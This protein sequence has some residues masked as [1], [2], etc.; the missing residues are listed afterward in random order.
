LLN[1]LFF[2]RLPLVKLIFLIDSSRKIG[3]GSYAQYVFAHNLA[4]LG[5][6]VTIF[7]GDKNFYS[8]NLDHKNLQVYYRSTIPKAAKGIGLGKLNRWWSWFYEW[9]VIRPYIKQFQP[10]WIIGYLHQSAIDA[11]SLGQRFNTKVANFVYETPEW[12]EEQLGIQWNQKE[13]RYFNAHKKAYENSTILIPNS[14]LAASYMKRWVPGV[15]VTQPVYPGINPIEVRPTARDYDIIYIGRLHKLKNVD[16][17]LKACKPEHKLALI[18][19]GEEMSSLKALAAQSN[20]NADFLGPVSDQEKWE[21]LNRSKLLVCPTRFEGFGMPPLEALACECK[22]LC[23]NIPILKEVY[24]NDVE[25]F[26]L[27]DV[28]GLSSKIDQLLSSNHQ[29]ESNLPQVYT[30]ENAAKTIE[31]ILTEHG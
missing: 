1:S 7:A 20:L 8:S 5:H 18:G 15:T 17:L 6:Q 12:M 22:V 2:D 30:W 29:Q 25:Y 24:G 13:R 23:S 28:A 11:A 4:K 3:G 19:S 9:R 21:Y 26:E 16:Q 31:K 27:D 14:K 10:D